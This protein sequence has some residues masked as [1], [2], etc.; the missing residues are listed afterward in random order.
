M[1]TLFH[2]AALPALAGLAL[3]A[4][5]GAAAQQKA[6][7]SPEKSLVRVNATLQ[8]YNFVRPWEKGAPTPR[9]GLGAVLEG[10][11]V[12]VTA[13]LIVN[14]TYIE[15]EHPSTGEKTPARILG[16]DYEANLAVLAPFTD[17]SGVLK[18]LVP[19]ELDLSV[20]SDDEL[21]VWQIEDNGDGVTTTV[22]VLRAS[23]G[24]YF[25]DGSVFLVYQTVGSLQARA[26]SFTLPVIK[27]GKLAGML[28][29]YNAKEQISQILAGPIIRA[30]LDDLEDGKYAGFPNLGIAFDQTID[31]QLRRF[32]GIADKEGGV[33]VSSVQKDSSADKAGIEVG[34]VILAINGKAIDSRGNYEHPQYGKLNF[35]HLV[36]G[37]AKVGDEAKFSLIRKGKATEVAVKLERKAP[38][39]Y[40]IDAYMFDRGPR[41]LILGGLIFQELTLPYLESWGDE[42]DTRAPFKLVHAQAHPE[43]Y[44][45]EGRDKL[46]F[47]SNVIR[48]PSTLGYEDLNSAIVTQVNGK[49]IKNIR[50][51]AAAFAKPSAEGL[52]R[53]EFDGFPNV[54]YIDDRMSRAVNQQLVQYGISLLEKLD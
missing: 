9:R 36:R 6:K 8:S 1:K 5:T 25:I 18:G 35:S 52:H 34:D 10:D 47:L 42:W 50:D 54:I 26:N 14:A 29:S 53:I 39:A 20:T 16:R 51:L 28:L 44:E 19:L 48:T 38:D 21:E 33:F 22:D 43:Q 17:K 23:V 11:R 3:L 27:N 2:R 40:L 24:E 46:V 49:P 15:L 45:E 12:L 30:F 31:E 4:P 13:E 37:A 7:P 41:Y 32:A